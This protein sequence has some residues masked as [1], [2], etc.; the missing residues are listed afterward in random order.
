VAKGRLV[1]FR[2]VASLA[3]LDSSYSHIPST[4]T[5]REA[6]LRQEQVGLRRETAKP[7]VGGATTPTTMRSVSTH[8]FETSMSLPLPRE[9]VFAFFADAVNLERITPP[10]LRF[11]IL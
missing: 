8:V 6:V 10:E 3:A 7:A 9:E 11:R 5:L 4:R 1:R 2:H